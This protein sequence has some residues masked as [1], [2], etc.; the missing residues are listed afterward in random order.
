MATEKQKGQTRCEATGEE[1][2]R[3][4]KTTA[5]AIEVAA[6]NSVAIRDSVYSTHQTAITHRLI[7][8]PVSGRC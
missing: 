2:G 3:E 1:E 8:Y 6:G 5:E 7:F 4:Q